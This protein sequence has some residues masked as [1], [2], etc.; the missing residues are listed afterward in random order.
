MKIFNYVIKDYKTRTHKWDKC[1]SYETFNEFL[2]CACLRG[3]DLSDL[4]NSKLLQSQSILIDDELMSESE[5]QELLLK[6]LQ[7]ADK[8][9]LKQHALTYSAYEEHEL[10][11]E[12]KNAFSHVSTIDEFVLDANDWEYVKE[13][14]IK[15]FKIKKAFMPLTIYK[16]L[17]FS[18]E[19]S[20]FVNAYEI[21]KNDRV[22]YEED[23][24]NPAN[25]YLTIYYYDDVK[26]VSLDDLNY[27]ENL[28]A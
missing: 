10:D 13:N 11:E 21:T 22:E 24:V 16:R 14:D 12:I 27:H 2:D 15:S 6:V 4:I 7:V 1:H 18:D 8:R 23:E 19:A 28:K 17:K 25:Q 9:M 20:R 3:N 26:R 5:I